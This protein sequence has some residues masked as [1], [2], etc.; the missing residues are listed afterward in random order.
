MP[1]L[2]P[3]CLLLQ[4]KIINNDCPKQGDQSNFT[5]CGIMTHIFTH[6]LPGHKKH[7]RGCISQQP[8]WKITSEPPGTWTEGLPSL[9]RTPISPL[10]T[11]TLR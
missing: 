8:R 4:L 6:P 1:E 7:P 5:G 3:P 11:M 2:I 10:F 9:G